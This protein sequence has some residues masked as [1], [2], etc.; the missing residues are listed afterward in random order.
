MNKH[1]TITHFTVD[2]VTVKSSFLLA[3]SGTFRE[4]CRC[5]KQ[6][7]DKFPIDIANSNVIKFVFSDE[8]HTSA[9]IPHIIE[10]E[11]YLDMKI[12]KVDNY[13]LKPDYY[14]TL[15]KEVV[16][17]LWSRGYVY[18]DE[19]DKNSYL[20]LVRSSIEQI[21]GFMP[22][23]NDIACIVC[24]V[25]EL[26]KEYKCRNKWKMTFPYNPDKFDPK[27][28]GKKP[29]HKNRTTTSF[30]QLLLGKMRKNRQFLTKTFLLT[31]AKVMTLDDIGN[32]YKLLYT[33]HN[34]KN[35]Y[36]NL[37]EKLIVS[38]LSKLSKYQEISCFVV[39]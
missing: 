14:R 27:Y 3:H 28:E 20:S 35:G 13:N 36:L 7:P 9:M 39:Q 33:S 30:Y 5:S 6:I 32:G 19:N 12:L 21:Y 29:F 26:L 10:M 24:L 8:S 1:V 25:D 34:D 2:V 38:H 16:Q 23:D 15:S 17:H 31:S 37:R 22:T 4:V 11:I 18:Y